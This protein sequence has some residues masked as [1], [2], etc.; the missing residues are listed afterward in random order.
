MLN[1]RM[2]QSR[3]MFRFPIVDEASVIGGL[4]VSRL[5]RRAVHGTIRRMLPRSLL[6]LVVTLGLA[7][8]IAVL[9]A[10]TGTVGQEDDGLAAGRALYADQCQSCHG[11]EGRGDGPA[12]RFLDPEPRDLTNANGW[13]HATEGTVEQVV[14]VIQDGID[15]TGMQPF[16]ELL[17]L[18]EMTT[19]ASYVLT[20]IVTRNN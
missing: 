2:V 13:V 1:G 3:L 14:A 15:D 6:V 10:E 19:V 20:A 18:Q 5:G 8:N 4:S 16:D 17:T 12:A 11:R 7:S 9:L